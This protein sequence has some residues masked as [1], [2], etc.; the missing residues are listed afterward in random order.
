MKYYLDTA[1]IEEIKKYSEILSLSGVTTNPSILKKE[2]NIDL[3]KHLR[4]IKKMI[5]DGEFHIQVAGETT[6]EMLKDAYKL[7]DEI[8]EDIFVK[9][10]VTESGLAAM[11]ELKENNHNVTATAIYTQFQGTLAISL[12]V[13]YIAPYYNR[14]LDL[15]ISAKDVIKSLVEITSEE[16]I[17]TKV[18]GASFKNISQVDNAAKIGVKYFTFGSEILEKSFSNSSVNAAVDKFNQ[19][20]KDCFK[21]KTISEI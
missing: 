14:M 8:G 15:N 2:G 10:P 3:F 7:Y 1:N 18:F 5:G 9:I 12:G 21:V 20:F 13:D 17:S 6:E 19:D 16:D 11:K 4:E